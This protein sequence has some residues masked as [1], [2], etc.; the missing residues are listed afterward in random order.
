MVVLV[1][2]EAKSLTRYQVHVECQ[3]S[4]A[5]LDGHHRN[6][7]SQFEVCQRGV[8]DASDTV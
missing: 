8:V 5:G 6:C 7:V 2:V 1:F 4:A 3:I